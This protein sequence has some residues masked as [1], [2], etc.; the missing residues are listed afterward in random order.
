MSYIFFL[1]ACFLQA[2]LQPLNQFFFLLL[3]TQ[4]MSPSPT[5]L[6]PWWICGDLFWFLHEI[7]DRLFYQA[8]DIFRRKHSFYFLDGTVLSKSRPQ[9]YHVFQIFIVL[10]GNNIVKYIYLHIFAFCSL[11]IL[12]II[13]LSKQTT[14]IYLID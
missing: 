11:R 3:S 9:V 1:F 5:A 13:A 12:H 2:A 4:D 6:C 10:K 7:K 14:T 8:A